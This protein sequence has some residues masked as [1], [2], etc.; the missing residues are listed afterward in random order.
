[1][2]WPQVRHP[3]P[4]ANV[5]LQPMQ[6]SAPLQPQT[7]SPYQQDNSFTPER[8]SSYGRHIDPQFQNQT[9]RQPHNGFSSEFHTGYQANGPHNLNTNCPAQPRQ[10]RYTNDDLEPIHDDPMYDYHDSTGSRGA[11]GAGNDS[12]LSRAMIPPDCST[13]WDWIDSPAYPN[14]MYVSQGQANHNTQPQVFH[15]NPSRRHES[16]RGDQTTFRRR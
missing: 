11:T 5:D 15:M 2:V 14:K 9:L 10:S 1:M 13:G 16:T 3:R 7:R 6:E 4:D 12:I 8:H